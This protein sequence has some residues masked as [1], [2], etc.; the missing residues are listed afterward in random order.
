MDSSNLNLLYEG[1]KECFLSIKLPYLKIERIRISE[2]VMQGSVW[3]PLLCTGTM[4]K[5]GRKA[6]MT[7]TSLYSYKDLVAIPPLGM[8][9]DEITMSKCSV[10]STKTN[11]FMNNFVE[12]KKLEFSDKK[13][14]KIHVGSNI[15]NCEKMKVHGKIGEN[16][17]SDKYI[18]DILS[19]D[20]TNLNL[21]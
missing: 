17:E 12:M 10:E 14:H 21:I 11:S 13:C 5:I 2:I 6:Y 18:G 7:G 19:D 8:V 15:K 16:V 4:D 3:G 20:G 1:S 9:D